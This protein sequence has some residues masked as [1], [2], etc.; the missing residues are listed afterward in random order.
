MLDAVVIVPTRET[1]AGDRASSPPPAS[2]R[3][4]RHRDL[5]RTGRDD[6][7]DRAA[8]ATCVPP[9]GFWLIT[10]PAGTVVLDAVRDRADR[11][12]RAGDRRRRRRLRQADDVRDATCAAPPARI[13]IAADV[14]PIGGRQ[15]VVD[16]RLPCRPIATGAE[17]DCTQNVSPT[18]VSTHSCTIV[19]PAPTTRG[20]P[21][22]PVVADAV[23]ERPA[24][25]SWSRDR[26]RAG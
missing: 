16:R 23:D 6:Q 20:V 11:Q 17:R 4:R 22:V 18:A 25:W 21:R 3:R 1:R 8:G 15:R 2:G 13:S 9:S 14:P 12:A 26:R 7:R 5:R 10:D 24:R 19:W